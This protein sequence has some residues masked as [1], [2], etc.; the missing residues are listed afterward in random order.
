MNGK[1]SIFV[2]HR[3]NAFDGAHCST[4]L[5]NINAIFVYDLWEMINKNN[6]IRISL[7]FCI[8]NILLPLIMCTQNADSFIASHI[9][10]I[11][12]FF[13]VLYFLRIICEMMGATLSPTWIQSHQT[14]WNKERNILMENEFCS[15]VVV[16]ILSFIP[17]IYNIN[18]SSTKRIWNDV[19]NTL[20]NWSARSYWQSSIKWLFIEYRICVW[21][22]G[23][24]RHLKCDQWTWT[25]C[26]V[27]S[28]IY[29][30]TNTHIYQYRIMSYVQWI[31]KIEQRR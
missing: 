28:R 21:F 10:R 4:P 7:S 9:A 13:L 20:M 29:T 26:K 24:I 16:V 3:T 19:F 6:K 8:L 12:V 1:R 27:Y 31:N 23:R 30:Y 15:A 17:N 14:A 11:R 2:Y 22:I 18:N 25:M 5:G